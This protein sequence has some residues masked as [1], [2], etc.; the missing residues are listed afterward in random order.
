MGRQVGDRLG[1]GVI[2]ELAGVIAQVAG[3]GPPAA[4]VGKAAAEDAVGARHVRGVAEDRADVG[5][6]SVAR[7]EAHDADRHARGR[8]D[9]ADEVA[10]SRAWPARPPR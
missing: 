6:G 7:A 5:L 3:E 1:P 2:A 10:R 4:R 8:Q 9:L